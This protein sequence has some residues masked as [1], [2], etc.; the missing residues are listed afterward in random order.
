MCFWKK[1]PGHLCFK[2]GHFSTISSRF[3]AN[4][5]NIFQKTEVQTVI[6]R[7]WMNLY[8][9]RLKSY[10]TKG[11][12]FPFPFFWDSVKKDIV[13][14]LPLIFFNS[15][16]VVM[17]RKPLRIAI[18]Q[19]YKLNL[20]LK[21]RIHVANQK[22]PL[23][24]KLWSSEVLKYWNEFYEIFG[25]QSC[26]KVQYNALFIMIFS[27][28]TNFGDRPL[29]MLFKKLFHLALKVSMQKYLAVKAINDI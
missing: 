16:W 27:P 19:F 24:L 2:N 28:V 29:E 8:L 23:I 9:N 18:L 10:D 11:F 20:N 6:F 13:K 12:F 22:S 4:Y 1:K 7:C 3:F 14:M 21:G 26:Q 5:I 25:I 15:S 17:V